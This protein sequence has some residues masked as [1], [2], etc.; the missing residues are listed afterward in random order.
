[1]QRRVAPRS[2]KAG[3]QSSFALWL[4]TGRVPIEL[5]FNP[6]HDPDNGRFTYSN[7]GRFF[8]D[9]GSVGN[10]ARDG[11]AKQG[12][13]RRK[14]NVMPRQRGPSFDPRDPSNYTEHSVRP[15][16]SLSKIAASRKGLKATDLAWLNRISVETPLRPGQ[17]IKVPSQVSLD[18]AKQAYDTFV[19]L[20]F[21]MQTHGGQLPPDAA[22]PPSLA[23]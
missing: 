2:E 22:H 20:D 4:R 3:R 21:Y 15:G 11:L 6:W 16:D 7:S 14:L 8:G 10:R 18:S 19:A 12:L 1:M 23:V 9:G 17:V 5:K 13:T